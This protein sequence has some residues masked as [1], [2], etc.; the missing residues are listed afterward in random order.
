MPSFDG[1]AIQ[2]RAGARTYTKETKVC[3]P[4]LI[5]N[6]FPLSIS[7]TPVGLTEHTVDIL[8]RNFLLCQ[9]LLVLNTIPLPVG[10]PAIPE[11]LTERA[12]DIHQRAVPLYQP[13]LVYN[14]IQRPGLAGVVLGGTSKQKKYR[15]FP[16]P[17]I[18][19]TKGVK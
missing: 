10:T 18:P 12:A 1:K 17:H 19:L 13:L 2:G 8:N 16:N 15:R 14:A 5:R 7:S 11:G 6:K 3:F 4:P 9:P